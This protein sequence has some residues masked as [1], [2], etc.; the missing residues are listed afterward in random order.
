MLLDAAQTYHPQRWWCHLW[1][2][3]PDHVHGLI[4]LSSSESLAKVVGDWKRFT[5]RR[6]GV[7]WQPNFFDH[8]IRSHESLDEKLAY[9][10]ANPVRAGLAAANISWPWQWEPSPTARPIT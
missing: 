8:R 10:C 1:L 3:M 9:V 2:V 5:H 6:T 7:A 4:A